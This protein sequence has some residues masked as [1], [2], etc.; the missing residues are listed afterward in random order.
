[1]PTGG[2]DITEE[3]IKGWFEAGVVAVG[4]GSKLISKDLVTKE[5]WDGIVRN[6]ANTL[7]LIKKY[8]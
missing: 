8:K 1:M 5:N 7:A 3:S 4:I 2:V 6:V